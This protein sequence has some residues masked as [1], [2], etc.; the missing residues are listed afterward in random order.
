MVSCTKTG[1]DTSV[2]VGDVALRTEF[3]GLVRVVAGSV[4]MGLGLGSVRASET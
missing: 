1:Q 4:R 2:G 3:G